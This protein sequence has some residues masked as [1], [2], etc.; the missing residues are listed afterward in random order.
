[1]NGRQGGQ[2][3]RSARDS[4]LD[5]C[6]RAIRKPVQPVA[7]LFPRLLLKS[8]EQARK[9]LFS[10]KRAAKNG[11]FPGLFP[12][13]SVVQAGVV[14]IRLPASTAL[15]SP[16]RGIAP[17]LPDPQRRPEA[18]ADSAADALQAISG[19]HDVWQETSRVL[20]PATC[21]GFGRAF[22]RKSRRRGQIARERTSST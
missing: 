13:L 15:N 6:W 3:G 5:S 18:W 11:G 12:L 1:M 20:H 16:S 10:E 9:A 21:T 17:A 19:G 2:T 7:G 4:C 22:F 8:S 14:P